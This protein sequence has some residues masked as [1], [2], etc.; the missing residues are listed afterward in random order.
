MAGAKPSSRRRGEPDRTHSLTVT[1]PTLLIGQSD[2]AFR[3]LLYNFFTIANRMDEIRRYLGARIGV[4]G[5]QC[6][7][8][9][10]VAELQGSTGVSVRKVAAYLHV[11]GPFVTTESGKLAAKGYIHRRP[12]PEDL[13]VSLLRLSPEGRKALKSLL[14][15]LRQINDLFFDLE[16]KEQFEMLCRTFDRLVE[17][18]RWALALVSLT[19]RDDQLR[20]AMEQELKRR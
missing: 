14:P 6:S 15:E 7:L 11:S 3:K 1:R 8:M 17:T 10:A 20:P 19:A 16:S 18:S 9:T 12:D 5:P 2:E 4:S 13:R